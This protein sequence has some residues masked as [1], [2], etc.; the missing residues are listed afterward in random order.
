VPGDGKVNSVLRER[1][2]SYVE[3]SF[4]PLSALLPLIDGTSGTAWRIGGT[5]VRLAPTVGD[6][7]FGGTM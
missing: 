5:V 4:E 6:S 1:E 7:T 2:R 3:F